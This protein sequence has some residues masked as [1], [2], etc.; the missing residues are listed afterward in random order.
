MKY[1]EILRHF[2]A[3]GFFEL[4]NVLALTQEKKTTVN[5]T[6]HRWAKA[7]LIVPLRRGLYAFPEDIAK[8]PMTVER[9]A[10]QIQKDT[11]VTGLWLLNQVGMIPE[12][13][14]EVTNATLGNP[15]KFETALG[16][17]TYQHVQPQGFFGYETK[18]DAGGYTV[19]TAFPEKALLDF[20]WWHKIEWNRPEFERWRIQ[21]PF[22]RLHTKRLRE[23][24]RRWNQPRLV[25][26]AENLTT[27][28]QAA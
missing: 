1:P 13:V 17:Y 27:Y 11:Y 19:R 21:D 5:V 20:F 12:G 26:A 25:R 22:R 10:N 8:N 16:R 4:P 15:A 9:A 2:G 6:L 14:I 18:L 7:G 24:A 23:F 28:L 3:F